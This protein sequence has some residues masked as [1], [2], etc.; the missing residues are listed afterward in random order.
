MTRNKQKESEL[1]ILR[2]IY[3]K[4]RFPKF[5][6][7]ERPDFI[8]HSTNKFGVEI[9]RFYPNESAARLY[10]KTNYAD[11]LA[12]GVG[13][14]KDDLKIL[15]S[16]SYQIIDEKQVKYLILVQRGFLMI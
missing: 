10:N 9:T 12:S 6:V 8:I 15:N 11:N 7:S 16:V 4:K 14:D 5:E 3:N 1:K 13:V 2:K